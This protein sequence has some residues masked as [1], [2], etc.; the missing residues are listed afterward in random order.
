MTQLITIPKIRTRDMELALVGESP[1]IVN[2]FSEKAKNMMVGKQKGEAR[3]KKAPKSAEEDFKNSLYYHPEGGYGFPCVG[4]KSAAV[5]AC[6]YV[7]GI[8]M[9]EARGAFHVVGE[10]AKIEGPEPEM[11]EDMVR[12]AMGTADVR[13]RGQFWPWRVKLTISYN[14]D[15]LT[16]EQIVNLFN[17]AGFGVGVGEWRPGKSGGPYGRFRVALE[18][19]E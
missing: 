9:T 18:G 3:M 2:R 15:A 13:Y 16:P 5:A 17:V 10:L 6:R 8:K 11:R 1:L 4:F 7:D 12:I 14:E 19:E